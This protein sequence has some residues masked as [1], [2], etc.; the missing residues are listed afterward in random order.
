[1][2]TFSKSHKLDNV[3][4]DI[5]GPVMDEANAMIAKGEHILKLNI[6]NPAP[7]RF[8]APAELISQMTATLT[9]VEGYSDSKGLYA[10]REA[11]AAYD[12]TKGIEGVTPDD[13]YTGNGASELITMSMQAL[14]DNGDEVLVPAPDYPLWTASVTLA[15]GTAVHYICDEQSDW[16]PDIEDM[17]KKITDKTKG[18]VI[19]NPNNPTG[20]LYPK[21]I[22][23]QIAQLARENGLIIFSDEIYDRLLMDGRKHTS[24]ASIC[25]DVFCVTFNGL[26]KS[27]MIAGFRCG[28]MSLSGDRK[29]VLGYI[30]GLN[31]LSSMRLCSN[32]PAQ[33][34]IPVALRANPQLETLLSPGGRIYE[35]RE[36]IVKR[37]NAID[38]I[39]AVKPQAAF[40]IFPRI[41]AKRFNI[42]DDER[43]V[44]DFLKAKHILLVH[45]GGFHWESPDHFRIVYLPD[46]DELKTSMDALED[47]LKTYKQS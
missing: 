44:L 8:R 30:E 47:F 4:Y 40:Y 39:S 11:I 46:V 38:G 34:V 7:F 26:S 19:I 22:L 43:F 31:M 33:A 13:I 32:V 45:G 36:Y 25:P 42:T 35:Q 3:C 21:E 6:G 23:E 28:W 12:K 10:A 2:K 14:L 5:R 27:H 15:G 29:N 18:I 20:S 24:I 1:M 17:R 16:Y 9:D 37:L 41:D